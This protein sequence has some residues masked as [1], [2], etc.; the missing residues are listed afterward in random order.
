[1]NRT[2]KEQAA[3]SSMSWQKT[4]RARAADKH[5]PRTRTLKRARNEKDYVSFRGHFSV[6]GEQ[7]RWRKLSRRWPEEARTKR[8]E[9]EHE[10]ACLLGICSHL[11]PGNASFDGFLC[12]STGTIWV[13]TLVKLETGHKN[14]MST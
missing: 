13:Y 11:A 7:L 6:A 14:I 5:F 12:V 10:G 9:T 4:S 8:R 2:E 3:E 1:M